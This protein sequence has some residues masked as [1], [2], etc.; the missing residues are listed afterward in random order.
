MNVLV[1]K[2]LLGT[3]IPDG[4]VPIRFAHERNG[5]QLDALVEQTLLIAIFFLA[6]ARRF[7]LSKVLWL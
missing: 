5:F 6:I 4:F 7:R 3:K 2:E 1:V